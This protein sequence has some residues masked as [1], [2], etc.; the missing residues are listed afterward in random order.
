MRADAVEQRAMALAAFLHVHL[1]RDLDGVGHLLH[2]VGVDDECLLHLRGCAGEARQHKDAG[3]L[4]RPGDAGPR[5]G[6]VS[7]SRRRAGAGIRGRSLRLL[8]GRVLRRRWRG[9]PTRGLALR[10]GLRP[11]HV[12]DRREE[13]VQILEQIV[14]RVV[15]AAALVACH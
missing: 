1:E 6:H 2:V 15:L 5:N 3:V 13:L 14:G 12:L 11:L 9:S 10:R 8:G 4:G 7:L